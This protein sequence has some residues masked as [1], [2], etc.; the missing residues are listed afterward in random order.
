MFNYIYRLFFPYTYYDKLNEYPKRFYYLS[1]IK[2]QNNTF[3][4]H[5][6]WP[7][8]TKTSYPTN[9]TDVTFDINKIETLLPD[10]NKNWYSNSNNE[11]KNEDFW[12]H[13][14]EKH[15]SCVFTPMTEKEY[16]KKT[17]DLYN[18]ALNEN[19]PIYFYD[20]E[21]K[22]CLIPVSTHFNFIVN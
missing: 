13:E 3:S 5:G 4:I 16:F 6:L 17:L 22:K 21:T 11:I 8:Y 15:G 18:V 9:C 12:K 19:L 10:L 7:Q 14:Y 20:K 2:E 1:L